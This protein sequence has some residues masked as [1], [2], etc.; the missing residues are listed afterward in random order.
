VVVIDAEE[1]GIG[2]MHVLGKFVADQDIESEFDSFTVV[3]EC[4]D[5]SVDLPLGLGKIEVL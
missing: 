1:Q 2:K 4:L 3:D 5:L